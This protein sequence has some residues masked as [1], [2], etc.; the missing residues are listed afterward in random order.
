MNPSTTLA[1]ENEVEYMVSL[2]DISYNSLI[3]ETIADN[4][5]CPVFDDRLYQVNVTGK[6]R[7]EE[8]TVE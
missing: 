5:D 4:I 2:F 8:G 6:N 3:S 1:C 7:M